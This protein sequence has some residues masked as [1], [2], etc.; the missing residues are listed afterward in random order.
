MEEATETEMAAVFEE[1]AA[2]NP[3]V[4]PIKI[5][6]VMVTIKIVVPIGTIV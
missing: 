2:H 6:P 4:V 3:V 5:A 1:V